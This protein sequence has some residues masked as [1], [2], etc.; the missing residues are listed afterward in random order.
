MPK[1]FIINNNLTLKLEDGKTNIY[2]GDFLFQQ[3]KF[4]LISIPLDDHE[5]YTNVG[6]IDDA[7]E[8]LDTSLEGANIER[9]NI[10]PEEEFWAHCSNLQAWYENEYD[11]RLL[12]SN[13]AFALLKKLY[14]IG[15]PLAKKKYK[16]ELTQRFLFGSGRIQDFLIEE[17][18]FTILSRE[19]LLNSV[20]DSDILFKLEQLL[21]IQLMANTRISRGFLIEDGIITWLSLDDCNIKILPEIIKN[22]KSVRG[23]YLS[24][25]SLTTLPKWIIDMEQLEYLN[26]SYNELEKIPK[27]IR[28]LRNLRRLELQYN[29]IEA[30]PNSIGE[31]SQLEILFL[32]KNLIKAIP[33]SIGMLTSLKDLRLG[34]NLI[35][36]LPESIGNLSSLL[37]L[38]I[39]DNP[40]QKIPNSITNLR[41]L[42]S[43]LLKGIDKDFSGL[44]K[45]LR[46]ENVLIGK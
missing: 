19:E 37:S 44:I 20:K 43:L 33:E 21:N 1:K 2:I 42:A 36:T 24:R 6:S 38:D 26:V 7:T 28:N 14:D 4:L 45:I 15:D 32:R 39:G 40:I 46:R 3:C 13:L 41:N 27:S 31:L 35:K 23:L 30:I 9:Y 29:K 22:L 17:G 5:A 34:G 11:T 16:E 18:Y 25:N 12:H 8:I 10:S